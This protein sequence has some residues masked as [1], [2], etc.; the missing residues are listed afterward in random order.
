MKVN[1]GK[2]RTVLHRAHLDLIRQ[3]KG[4]PASPIS[5]EDMAVVENL[6][7]DVYHA[8]VIKRNGSW[9]ELDF[10]EDKDF[11]EFLLRWS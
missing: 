5:M 6:W 1:V 4:N 10:A 7:L 3:V 8:R 11:T 2:N 9:H